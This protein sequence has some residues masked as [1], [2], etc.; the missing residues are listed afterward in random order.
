M[1]FE[2]PILLGIIPIIALGMLFTLRARG[3]R[4]I[5]SL[6]IALLRLLGLSSII[7][8]TA[9]PFLT[10]ERGVEGLA[11][12]VDISSSISPQQG[13]ELLEKARALSHELGIPLTVIPFGGSVSSSWQESWQGPATQSYLELR[14]VWERLDIGAT[15]LGAA[16]R[17]LGDRSPS[18][19]LLLSDG[20]ETAGSAASALS[21]LTTTK[22]FP[23][24]ALGESEDSSLQISQLSVPLTVQAQKSAEIRVALTNSALTA[25]RGELQVLHGDSVVFSNGVEIKPGEDLL[26]TT[27]SDSKLEGLHS[28]TA[29][30]SWQ[31]ETGPHSM[32]RT[33]WLTSEKRNKVLLLSGSRDDDRLLSTILTNQAYQLRSEVQQGAT[34]A[35]GALGAPA[36]YRVVILNNVPAAAIPE[37]FL[38]ALPEFI[39]EGGGLVM[40]GGD[41]SFGLGGYIGSHIEAQLPVLLVPPHTEKKRLNVAVQLVID[42]SRSMAQD[43]RLEFAKTAAL[44][45]VRILKDDDYVGVIGFEEVAFIAL[46]ISKVRDVR[47]TAADRISRLFPTNR[48]NLY[49]ALEE[50]RRG[51]SRINA[52]RKHLI[53]LTDGQIPDQGPY[54]LQ[55]IKQLRTLG[56]TVSTVLVGSE[57]PDAFLAQLSEIG[58]GSFY[59]T[60]DPQNLPRIFLSDVKVSTGEQTIKEEPELP[61][62]PGPS[63]IVTTSL[64]N[65]PTLRGFVQTIAR[66]GASTELLVTEAAGKSFPLLASWSVGKGRAIAFTSDANGRWS[67]NWVR[68]SELQGFWSDLVE[69]AQPPSAEKPTT[70]RFDLRS[71]VEGGELVVDLALFDEPQEGGRINASLVTPQGTVQ[72]LTLAPQARGHYQGRLPSAMAGTYKATISIGKQRLPEVAWSLPGELFGEHPHRAPNLAL[73]EQISL[74]SGGRLNPRAQELRQFIKQLSAKQDLA[75]IFVIAALLLLFIEIIGREILALRRRRA[76]F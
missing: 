14:R 47:Q 28:V 18:V 53:V 41:R 32:T 9:G 61:V 2:Y 70:T 51:L 23:L 52:G 16:L 21:T 29:T 24:T 68:W 3:S 26:V 1:N 4:T 54:Y 74:R 65:F 10:T 66:D 73:L 27:E 38:R 46:P 45:V 31:D 49:P 30:L 5:E 67:S 17:S 25:Q 11:T 6:T 56:I 75:Q 64:R 76:S 57:T 37:Q 13:E 7:V 62:R 58:G 39:K 69:S 48:T 72:A 15:D 35:P 12:L 19:A 44:E 34:I 42:K 36:D 33:A 43:N 60:E 55:L 20:Y 50:G 22:I 8:A 40:V 71:W 63:G 59:Q